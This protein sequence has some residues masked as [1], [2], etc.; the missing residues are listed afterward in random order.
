[1]SRAAVVVGDWA[2]SVVDV[3]FAADGA[4]FGG[5]DE[6]HFASVG[7]YEEGVGGVATL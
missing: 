3:V 1:M 7:V 5:G 6:A 2:W 4:L